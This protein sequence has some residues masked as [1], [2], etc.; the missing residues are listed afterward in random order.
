MTSTH[1]VAVLIACGV[2]L[3]CTTPVEILTPPPSPTPPNVRWKTLVSQVH[4]L[5]DASN[6]FVQHSD[7]H[8]GMANAIW[9]QCA[10]TLRFE[11]H[12]IDVL[13]G[14]D[15]ENN[16]NLLRLGEKFPADQAYEQPHAGNWN[17]I[18]GAAFRL[19]NSRAKGSD[20]HYTKVI[21]RIG[22][23]GVSHSFTIGVTPRTPG[24][25]NVSVVIPRDD[26][27]NI[28]ILAHEV[29]HQLGLGYPHAPSGNLM[30]ESINCTE[31]YLTGNLTSSTPLAVNTQ[32]RS[33]RDWG[34]YWLLFEEP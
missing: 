20:N 10:I 26:G 15:P 27:S 30:C 9:R 23:N 28:R 6:V 32:C 31:P 29:G 21:R 14:Y 25:D 3:G 17:V 2:S 16:N 33:A 4:E 1:T 18:R 22:S 8:V 12:S 34:D 24:P 13:T 19:H 7:K 5:A 11:P